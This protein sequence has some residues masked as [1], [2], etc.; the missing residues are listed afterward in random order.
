MDRHCLVLFACLMRKDVLHTTGEGGSKR[1]RE[2]EAKMEG[3][4]G[5]GELDGGNSEVEWTDG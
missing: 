1:E 3:E 2:R 4:E 5:R